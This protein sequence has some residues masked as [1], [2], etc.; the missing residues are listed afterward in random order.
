MSAN[1]LNRL[2]H[3]FAEQLPGLDVKA[4]LLYVSP[5]GHTI[6]GVLLER[7][8]DANLFYVNVFL[9]PLCIPL[10]T[11]ALNTGKRIYPATGN[12]RLDC[13]DLLEELSRKLTDD[14]V[15]YLSAL[16]SPRDVA[17]AAKALNLSGDPMV[18]RTV[19]YAF[20]RNG[21]IP[22]SLRELNGLLSHL[23]EYG[24]TH[25]EWFREATL[26]KSLLE[27]DPRRAATLL[28]NWEK[29]T[30]KALGIKQ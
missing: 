1:Q 24:Q 11:F 10:Q 28:L 8:S 15:P 14:V 6:R 16:Q 4:R 13:P 27:D 26:L 18:R 9:Q 17:L 12:W 25:D 3:R 5:V 30:A 22:Q 19:A 2:A 7:S 21:D 29:E 23:E 20:A